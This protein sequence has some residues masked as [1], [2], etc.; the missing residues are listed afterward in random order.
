MLDSHNA[1]QCTRLSTMST[2][3]EH[4]AGFYTTFTS[5]LDSLQAS[6]ASATT[7]T[8]LDAVVQAIIDSRETLQ[9]KDLEGH[10]PNRDKELYE[11]VR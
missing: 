5:R 9:N 4:S 11:R 2:A 6:I 10:L 1:I 7:Q 3:A 8:D